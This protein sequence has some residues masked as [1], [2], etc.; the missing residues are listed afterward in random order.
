MIVID[1]EATGVDPKHHSIISIGAI[2]FENPSNEFYGECSIWEGAEIMEEAL[3]VNGFTRQDITDPTKQS[4][5]IL[6]RAFTEWCKKIPEHTLAGH[7][8]G[9]IDLQF[10]KDSAHRSHIN[11]YFSYRHID[12]HSLTYMHLV[13]RG[14]KPP[15]KN[16]RTDINAEFVQKYVG[17]TE[18]GKPHNAL[19]DA[20]WT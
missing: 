12:T 6:M 16:G 19:T 20:R 9:D 4:L 3:A 11:F 15:I 13:K 8:L 14:I 7:N 17:I 2:E 18:V 1:V 5:E 10:L